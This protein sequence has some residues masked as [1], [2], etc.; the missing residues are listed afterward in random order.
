MASCR[1]PTQPLEEGRSDQL[2]F[3]VAQL[4]KVMDGVTDLVPLRHPAHLSANPFYHPKSSTIFCCT[5]DHSEAS[6]M[7]KARCDRVP[8][9]P[10]RDFAKPIVRFLFGHPLDL[11]GDVA[12][13]ARLLQ[14]LDRQEQEPETH[15]Q[16]L[17]ESERL[18][19][20]T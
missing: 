3:L 20:A 1:M 5:Q 17:G 13:P 2:D 15:A 7:R 4:E 6:R 9:S 16:V 19:P 8:A 10:V 12:H 18:F 14:R 11:L